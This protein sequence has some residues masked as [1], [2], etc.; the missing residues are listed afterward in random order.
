MR[1]SH[2]IQEIEKYLHGKLST[3]QNL[4]FE[5]RM[6]VDPVLKLK[7]ACQRKLHAV[8]KHSGR[9]N[10][11]MEAARIHKKLFEDPSKES[12]QYSIFQLFSKR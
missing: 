2:E 4:I 12:F 7:V 1:T 3:P 11:K 9:R 10:I 8:I 5:A 6:L